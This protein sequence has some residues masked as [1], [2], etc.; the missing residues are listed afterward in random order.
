MLIWIE[1]VFYIQLINTSFLLDLFLNL[2]QSIKF[3][4]LDPD[5]LNKMTDQDPAGY[6]IPQKPFY[7]LCIQEVMTHFIS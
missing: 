7:V 4:R 5:R 1:N 2:K 6:N 3:R